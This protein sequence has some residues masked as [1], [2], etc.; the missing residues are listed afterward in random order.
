[1]NKKEVVKDTRLQLRITS[2]KL[3]E[4]KAR[5][6]AEGLTLS[7]YVTRCIECTDPIGGS[8]GDRETAV[9]CD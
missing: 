2:E 1:M 6:E 9:E 5:A 7:E 8:R 4:Y 3:E